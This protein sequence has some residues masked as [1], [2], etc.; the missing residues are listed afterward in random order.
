MAARAFDL[1]GV[2]FL[3]VAAR[4]L[5]RAVVV[6]AAIFFVPRAVVARLEAR[7]EVALIPFLAVTG[8]FVGDDFPIAS[9]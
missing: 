7:V 3:A 2:A 1:R 5:L 8:G 6:D 9:E 4:L